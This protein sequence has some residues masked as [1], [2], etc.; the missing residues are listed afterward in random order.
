MNPLTVIR[1]RFHQILHLDS[2]PSEIFSATALLF[3]YIAL[4][5]GHD[6][7]SY[8]P[9][10]DAMAMFA[11]EASWG[12]LAGGVGLAQLFS[13]SLNGYGLRRISSVLAMGYWGF[14]ASMFAVTNVYQTG[15]GIYFLL[16]ASNAWALHQIALHSAL[17]KRITDKRRKHGDKSR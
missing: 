5:G 12:R 4:T 6:V 16:M 13:V 2:Q 15:T 11:K 17:Q 7:F 10:F 8:S 14:V 3:W 1:R 9:S